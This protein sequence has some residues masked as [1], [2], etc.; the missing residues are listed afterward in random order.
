[1]RDPKPESGAGSR[2][3]LLSGSSFGTLDLGLAHRS[4]ASRTDWR[5]VIDEWRFDRRIPGGKVVVAKRI[6]SAS[7]RLE[8]PPTTTPATATTLPIRTASLLNPERLCR[9]NYKGI[10]YYRNS[11]DLPADVY[12]LHGTQQPLQ[13][14]APNLEK[15]PRRLW[16]LESAHPGI[17]EHHEAD[18]IAAM[19]T[20]FS[21]LHLA[22]LER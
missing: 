19:A 16:A 2:G 10:A 12:A 7:K 5:R 18:F 20:P 14:Q 15:A 8:A 9:E 4:P 22:A 6:A 1:M 21:L 3:R 13:G 17:L 11:P